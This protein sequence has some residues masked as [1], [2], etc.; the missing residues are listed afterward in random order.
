[1][2]VIDRETEFRVGH[3]ALTW[4]EGIMRVT[5]S[6]ARERRER[7]RERERWRKVRE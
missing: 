3:S 7:E 4:S 5:E 6:A 2:V 1:M